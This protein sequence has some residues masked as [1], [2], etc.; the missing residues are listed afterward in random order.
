[1]RKGFPL[2]QVTEINKRRAGKSSWGLFYLGFE[3]LV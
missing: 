1:M 2:V 3:K